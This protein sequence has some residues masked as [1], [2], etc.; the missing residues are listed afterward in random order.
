MNVMPYLQ[1]LETI[2]FSEELL[3]RAI[4]VAGANRLRY[5]AL[6]EAVAQ[7]GLAPV[8]ALE[9]LERSN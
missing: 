3:D 1:K 8:E 2:G 7:E 9:L 6:Y 5:T 4:V